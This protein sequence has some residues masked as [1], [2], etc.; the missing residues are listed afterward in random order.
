MGMGMNSLAYLPKIILSLAKVRHVAIFPLSKVKQQP[1][2]DHISHNIAR[3][4]DILG[5]K[6]IYLKRTFQRCIAGKKKSDCWIKSYG[7][8]KISR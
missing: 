7:H 1:F 3:I 6:E 4:K 2:G 8:L 5:S